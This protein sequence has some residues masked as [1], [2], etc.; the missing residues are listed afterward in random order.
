M[1]T[2]K[3]LYCAQYG[4]SLTCVADGALLDF[5]E[6]MDLSAVFGN[7]LEEQF[8]ADNINE[9]LCQEVYASSNAGGGLC[10]P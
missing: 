1:L 8:G 4:I 10:R 7:A 3:S 6:V 2:S 5:I 9:T